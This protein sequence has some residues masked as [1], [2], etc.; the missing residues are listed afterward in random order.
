MEGSLYSNLSQACESS[1]GKTTSANTPLSRISLN[2]TFAWRMLRPL[3]GHLVRKWTSFGH[4]RAF[5]GGSFA[6]ASCALCKAT[7]RGLSTTSSPWV[8]A[9]RH[10]RRELISV[11]HLCEELASATQ[12]ASKVT[13]EY[14][15]NAKGS[16]QDVRS[17]MSAKDVDHHLCG[18][19]L[20][21]WYCM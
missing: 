14:C 21:Q 17:P 9:T 18:V 8:V 1:S 2:Q 16:E 12:Q 3:S 10:L 11:C 19:V 4:Q 5:P 15:S 6:P 20:L 7:P 13:Y